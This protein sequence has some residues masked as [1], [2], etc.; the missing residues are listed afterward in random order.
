MGGGINFLV[1]LLPDSHEAAVKHIAGKELSSRE[2]TRT[3]DPNK[4]I[5][6]PKISALLHGI[7]GI[8]KNAIIQQLAN[9]KASGDKGLT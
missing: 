3:H 2:F 5:G 6:E 9:L 7:P 8:N 4:P 1:L